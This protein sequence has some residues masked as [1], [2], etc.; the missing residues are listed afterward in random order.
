[1]PTHIPNLQMQLSVERISN[2]NKK[3]TYI[4]QKKPAY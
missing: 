4:T 3:I 2:W 1:M